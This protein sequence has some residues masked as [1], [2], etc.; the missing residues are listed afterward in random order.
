MAIRPASMLP[1]QS[2]LGVHALATS[3]LYPADRPEATKCVL[4]PAMLSKELVSQ[5]AISLSTSLDTWYVRFQRGNFENWTMHE[6]AMV[7]SESLDA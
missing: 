4:K 5:R 3:L 6:V 1:R 7:G 2:M